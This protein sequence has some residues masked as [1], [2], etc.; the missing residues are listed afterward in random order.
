MKSALLAV[1][2]VSLV[3]VDH[4]EADFLVKIFCLLLVSIYIRA[5]FKQFIQPSVTQVVW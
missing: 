5:I 1:R 3:S 2:F 4:L